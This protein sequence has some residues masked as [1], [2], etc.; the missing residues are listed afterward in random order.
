MGSPPQDQ[1]SLRHQEDYLVDRQDVYARQRVELTC[2]NMPFEFNTKT[3]SFN[4]HFT[5]HFNHLF[6]A[7][8]TVGVFHLFPSRTQKLSLSTP[9]VLQGQ[10][11]GRV[12]YCRHILFLEPAFTAGSLHLITLIFDL[13]AAMI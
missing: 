9:M 6:V 8:A 4:I 12:G 1:I 11:C 10:P 7:V 5:L 13:S 2:T 3:S